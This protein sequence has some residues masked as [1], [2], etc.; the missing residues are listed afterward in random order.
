MPKIPLVDVGS[1]G[2]PSSARQNINENFDRI[3]AAFDDMLDRKGRD[4]NQM[5]ADLDMGGH[6]ILNLADPTNENDGVNLRSVRPLVEQFAAELVGTTVFGSIVVDQFISLAAQTTFALSMPPGNTEN[7]ELFIDGI[8]QR[9]SADFVLDGPTFQSLILLSPL[10][11]GQKVL[12]RYGRVLPLN[13]TTAS[14]VTYKADVTGSVTLPINTKVQ[15]RLSILDF[16]A[17]VHP[18]DS[19]AA[20]AAAYAAVA[21]GGE[22]HIP[23]GAW[24][25]TA[26]ADTGKLMFWTGDG[27]TTTG[28]SLITSLPGDYIGN[29]ENSKLWNRNHGRAIDT[30]QSRIRRV[31]D[32]TGGT[33]GYVN[34][35]LRV[36]TITSPGGNS[37]EWSGL[38]TLYNNRQD[39]DGAEDVALYAQATKYS[40]GKTWVGC[41]EFIDNN[42]NPTQSSVTLEMDFRAKSDDLGSNRILL[43][44]LGQTVDGNP[45]EISKGLT[46]STEPNAR[47]RDAIF[48]TGLNCTN[49][50]SHSNGRITQDGSYI[51]TKS[52]GAPALNGSHRF[53]IDGSNYGVI[54]L[55]DSDTLSFYVGDE[56]N[57][58]YQMKAGSFRPFDDGTKA[59]GG[60]SNRWNTVY[61]V[62]GTINTSDENEKEAITAIPDAVLDA[63]AE[64]QYQQF[65]FKDSVT[66]KGMAA[67]THVGVIAQRVKE[68]FEAHGIDP[69]EYGILCRDLVPEE[70][71][72]DP[73]GDRERVI[74]VPRM[75]PV[76]REE[77]SVEIRNGVAMVTKKITTTEEPVFE[78][79]P[80]MDGEG[81]PLMDVRPQV[82]DAT[83]KVIREAASVPKMH[84]RQATDEVR[85]RYRVVPEHERYGVRYEE[86]LCLEAA[87]LRR[88]LNRL[89]PT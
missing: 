16:G 49:L 73:A 10:V 51:T 87:L 78:Y 5:E 18:Y 7:V 43:H 36:E 46:I 6:Q 57:Q 39:A 82:T 53:G 55:I 29:F 38:F 14:S 30:P 45:A 48:T 65:K 62:T 59:L 24:Y 52:N 69:F 4:P 27:V 13:S 84:Q 68:A 81:N 47:I 85:I 86:A 61:A 9:P 12:V 66:E 11:A 63:W 88:E 25:F 17:K 64:V 44:M 83:G 21:N 79:F 22:I 89:I 54:S 71:I 33:I 35:A 20:F 40:T 58:R 41:L 75:V 60:S 26:P 32:Y 56:I 80:M 67:R 28:P 8:A 3:E 34:P 1:L 42:A 31:A 77:D 2:N 23:A 19:T 15:E 76:S 74:Q 72:E 50:W 70:E 37:Y